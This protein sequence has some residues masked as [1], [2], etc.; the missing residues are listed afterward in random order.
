MPEREM[1]VP[2]PLLSLDL[3]QLQWT[4]EPN[5]SAHC[6]FLAQGQAYELMAR[7]R[8]S[9][10]GIN[11]QLVVSLDGKTHIE[12]TLEITKTESNWSAVTSIAKAPDCKLRALSL[13][14]RILD[15]IQTVAD[16]HQQSITHGVYRAESEQI[17]GQPTLSPELWEKIFP[18]ILLERNYKKMGAGEWIKTYYPRTRQ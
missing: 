17:H 4:T 12:A 9:Q 11:Y 18:P 2:D 8:S 7:R 10:R 15:Y 13:N 5:A 16:E 1:S 6:A 14:K 3:S